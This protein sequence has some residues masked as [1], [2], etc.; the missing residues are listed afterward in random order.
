MA[1]TVI[2][3]A[4]DISIDAAELEAKLTFTPAK[5]GEDWNAER[6]LK[7]VA[8]KRLTPAPAGRALE[9][10]LQKLAKAKEA[11]SFV[12]VRGAPAEEATPERIIWADLPIPPELAD[13]AKEA[14]DKAK[15]P[16][17]YRVRVEKL[18]IE[19]IVK[20]PSHIPFLPPKEEVVVTWDKKETREQVFVD[21]SVADTLY[22]EKGQKIGTA[23]A[24]KPGKPG[25][26][27]FGKPVPPAAL[28]DPSFLAGEGIERDKSEL[29]AAVSGLVRIGASW[30]DIVPLSKPKWRV[31]KG[32]DGATIYF[33]FEPGAKTL[34]AP[35]ANDVVSAAVAFGVAEEDLMPAA[36]VEEAIAR[37]ARS[38]VPLEAFPLSLRRDGEVV[39]AVAPDAL[40]ATLTMR[41]GVGGGR[42]LELKDVSEAIRNSRVRGFQAEKAK[43]DILA[44]FKGQDI[45]L[46]DY[47]LVE[48]KAPTRGKDREIQAA[49]A[50]LK[51]EARAELA[52]RVAASPRSGLPT[53]SEACFPPREATHAAFVE[54][55]ALV[56]VVTQPPPGVS[57][58]DVFGAS[59]PGLPGNDP[60]VRPLSGLRM[61]G[62]EI[63][64]DVSGALMVKKTETSFFGY[65]LPYR[66]S[67]IEVG[68]SNDAMSATLRL[69]REIGAGK[70]LNAESVGKALADAGVVRGIDGNL[71][72]E[73][74]TAAL[75]RGAAGPYEVARGE[76]A[77][78]GGSTTIR[79]LIQLP[80]GKAVTVKENGKADFKNQDKF[81]SVAAGTPVAEIVKIGADGRAGFDVTGK[82]IDA[83]KGVDAQV[84]HDD[85]V[86]EQPIEGGVRLVAGRT[87]ELSFDGKSLSIN[88]LHGIKG[89]VG[90]ATGNVNFPGEVRVS[91][92]VKPGF[93]VIGSADVL[94][95]GP[96]EAALVSAGGKAVI[97]QGVVGG[98]K[99]IVRAKLGIETIYAERATLL[100]VQNIL[101]KNGCVQCQVKTNGKLS[102]PG[103]RGHLI[104][105]VCKA[106]L[107]VDAMNIGSESG[108]HT[109]ISFGQDYLVKDQIESI[110]RE[111][112]KV[113]NAL[114]ELDKKLKSIES[115]GPALDAARSE[116][117]RLMKYMEK[118]G[119]K[120]F[121]LREKFEEHN[122]S[123]VRVRGAVFPGVVLESHG[124]YFEVKQRKSAVV[125]VFDREIGRI[126]EK[127]LT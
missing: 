83:G 51:D 120:L 62:S 103:E 16:E 85:S 66:D 106:R 61:K 29:R 1:G 67:I 126:Q 48:G 36:D 12:L 123:E 68:I 9:D 84:A 32:Q 63:R 11:T 2:K 94:I 27:V 95:G 91:G 24:P 113:K 52:E 77:V 42:P 17:L 118:I 69:A 102:L 116:K 41:K 82:V 75:E 45:E 115:A 109:E 14:L 55:D 89:D 98:G 15:P 96:A 92:G 7:L 56:A 87:G 73:V 23:A 74:L 76:K 25:K 39:V 34:P 121:T 43:A 5:D 33:W 65:V 90:L 60:D 38:G 111:T 46:V 30:A 104:G 112:E 124:R 35:A 107:G 80:T 21:L 101:A 88:A 57:G 71:V 119:M 72:S 93:A 4:V 64:S 54:K 78:A 114:L 81:V 53:D 49:V 127:P 108:A 37:A 8:E 125:F 6:I 117:V 20:K 31:E 19:T 3:G 26:N 18:K 100:A 105:G 99:G 50:F 97:A 86:T 59:L 58:T 28:G 70:P 110:E 79:W 10:A 22:A 13:A 40:K 122:P 44:F 47:P